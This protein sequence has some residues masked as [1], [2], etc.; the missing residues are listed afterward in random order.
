MSERVGRASLACSA[1]SPDRAD[2]ALSTLVPLIP[3]AAYFRFQPCDER[4][5]MALDD[6]DP[7]MW[8]KLQVR[9][10]TRMHAHACTPASQYA[11]P[12]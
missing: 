1:T 2:E 10:G 3:G 9:L 12:L 6:V 4:C 5:N 11:S 7:L 8:A